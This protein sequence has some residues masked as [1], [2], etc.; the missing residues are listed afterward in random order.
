MSGLRA[1]R[2]ANACIG[3]GFTLLELLVVIALLSVLMGGVGLYRMNENASGRLA[4]SVRLLG[5][6]VNRARTQAMVS[7]NPTRLCIDHDASHSGYLSML[8][9]SELKSGA[10]M[11]VGQQVDLSKGIFVIP[12]DR[13]RIAGNWKGVV[14]NWSDGGSLV[15]LDLDGRGVKEYAYLEFLAD[16]TLSHF[17]ESSYLAQDVDVSAGAPEIFISVGFV[18]EDLRLHVNST[19]LIAGVTLTLRGDIRVVARR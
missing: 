10:W 7:G 18:G 14:S 8:V 3:Q 4:A 15:R 5:V 9:V 19:D 17:P 13:G 6:T 2:H 12:S 11:T 16:G 1:S